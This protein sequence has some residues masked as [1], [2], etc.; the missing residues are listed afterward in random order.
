[1]VTGG[2]VYNGIKHIYT[3]NEIFEIDISGIR[4]I[5]L[6]Y[7]SSELLFN[8]I[9]RYLAFLNGKRMKPYILPTTDV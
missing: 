8:G 7:Q 6:V 3:V 5:F 1:M 9:P 4:F 2:R